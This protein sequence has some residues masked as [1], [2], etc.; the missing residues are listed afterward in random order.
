MSRE[1]ALKNIRMEPCER[2]GH[3][4][5]SLDYHPEYLERKVG[6]SRINPAFNQKWREALSIDFNWSINDGLINWAQAGRVTDLGHAAYASD[7]SDERQSGP[8]PF[9]SVE[10]VWSFDAVAEYG[11]PDQ[12]E[13]V[14][15]YEAHVNNARANFPDQLTS[16]GTYKTIVSGAIETFGWDMLLMGASD[17]V[18]MEKV[19]D[20]FFRRS[21]FLFKCWA[22]TSAE[23]LITHDDF[24]WSSGAFMHPDIYRKVIIPRYAELWKIAHAAGK[25]V[26]FCADGD[27]TQFAADIVNAGADGLIFEPMN[28]FGFMVDNFA[29]T[30]C[31]IGSFVD[32]RDMTFDHWDKVRADIDQTFERLADCRGALL[33]V[34]NHLPSNVPDEM[35]DRYFD[36]LLPR[37]ALRG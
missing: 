20:S 27:F 1:V 33:A 24:V 34:G 17:P 22:Q 25:K 2:W 23:V 21:V 28:D 36:E 12:Q 32:C 16:G 18:Q 19:F 15:A 14:A 30:T 31:L 3:T 6:M 26:L 11:L 9:E 10:A 5:Y 8:C 7:G 29:K 35:L 4:Q 37:L 13:Q